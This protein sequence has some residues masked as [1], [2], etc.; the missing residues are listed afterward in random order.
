MA[1]AQRSVGLVGSPPIQKEAY[2]AGDGEDSLLK[3][4]GLID[5]RGQTT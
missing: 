4:T 3:R 2:N 5:L 1:D